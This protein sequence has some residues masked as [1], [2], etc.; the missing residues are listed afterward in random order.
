[1]RAFR[2]L[3]GLAVLMN[4]LH[5]IHAIHHYY[6]FEA[7]HGPGTWALLLSAAVLD[8]LAFAGGV[9]LLAQRR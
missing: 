1:M 8:L 6:S 7:T 3:A 2:I 4:A 9:L 5:F